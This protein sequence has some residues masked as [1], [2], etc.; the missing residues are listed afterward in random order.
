MLPDGV[1]ATMGR[2]QQTWTK[3]WIGLY[4]TPLEENLKIAPDGVRL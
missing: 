1:R 4:E 3:E 2:R